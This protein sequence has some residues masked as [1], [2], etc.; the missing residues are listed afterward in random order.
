MADLKTTAEAFACALDMGFISTADAQAWIDR[1][2]KALD[3][4]PIELIEA[5][6]AAGSSQRIV[7]A[8][9]QLPGDVDRSGVV[10]QCFR[11]ARS[12]LLRDTS[13]VRP[14]ADWLFRL[15]V[16]K[17]APSPDAES[18]MYWFDDE[19]VRSNDFDAVIFE[20]GFER[21]F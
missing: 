17:E 5:C 3:R 2:M 4:P 14:I 12:A 20:F 19:L 11:H 10:R 9:R 21:R 1:Q 16:D 18:R 15:A 6:G 13:M 7:D 8:L